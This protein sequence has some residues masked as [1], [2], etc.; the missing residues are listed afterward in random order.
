MF[1]AG[2]FGK[3]HFGGTY[4]GPNLEA[5]SEVET[6]LGGSGGKASKKGK[7]ELVLNFE[8]PAFRPKEVIQPKARKLLEIPVTEPD[9]FNEID[10][11]LEAFLERMV[12]QDRLTLLQL[13]EDELIAIMLLMD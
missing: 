4:Y 10:L 9:E 11:K 1:G 5:T 13:D 2:Y 7:G 3:S 12:E 6:P 8:Q